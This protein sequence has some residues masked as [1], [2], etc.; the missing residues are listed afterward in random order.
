ME[1]FFTIKRNDV[2][3]FSTAWMNMNVENLLGERVSHKVPHILCFHIHET[4]VSKSTES[5]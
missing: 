3:K 2:V 4:P 1:Y 5:G